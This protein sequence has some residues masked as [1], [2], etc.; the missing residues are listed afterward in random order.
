MKV[1]G[2]TPPVAAAAIAASSAMTSV[3]SWSKLR[4]PAARANTL[5]TV[6]PEALAPG[7]TVATCAAVRQ[8]WLLL[9][10]SV[11]HKKRPGLV[12]GVGVGGDGVGG[13]GVAGEGLGGDG[14]GD[15]EGLGARASRQ[16][17]AAA[18]SIRP[19]SILP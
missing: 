14:D 8:T 13:L 2:S 10:L 11:I 5:A 17:Y 7:S 4:L 1:S 9:E 19:P 12:G 18:A 6:Q 3:V 15:G 16:S